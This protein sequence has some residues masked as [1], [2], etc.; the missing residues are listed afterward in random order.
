M[1]MIFAYDSEGILVAHRVPSGETINKDYYKT[2]LSQTLK[3]KIARKRPNLLDV[4]P[5]ILQDNASCHKAGTVTSLLHELEWE[6]LP[7]PAYSPDISPPDFDLFPKLK[8]PLRGIR[9]N[10]LDQLQDAVTAGVRR[11]DSGCLATGIAAL[12]HRWQL[13]INH[14][15]SYFEG[16]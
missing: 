13:V 14:E 10:D 1:L 7:H 5:I 16:M 8:E 3:R 11:I 12:P 9:Y 4:G 15:G 6:V 2:F